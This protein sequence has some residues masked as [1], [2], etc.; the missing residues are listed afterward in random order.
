MM[1]RHPKQLDVPTCVSYT[2][3]LLSL[4]GAVAASLLLLFGVDVC[5]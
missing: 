1:G 2:F 3:L 5:R 4:F